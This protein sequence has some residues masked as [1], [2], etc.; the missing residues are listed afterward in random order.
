MKWYL[1]DWGGL[2]VWLFHRINDIHSD[3]LD[4]AMLAV[5]AAAS[6]KLFLLYLILLCLVAIGVIAKTAKE[7]TYVKS[8]WISTIAVFCI[9]YFLDSAFVGI[10]K[11]LMDFPRPPLALSIETVHIIGQAEYHHSL[12]SG[13]SSFAMLMVATIWPLLLAPWQKYIAISFVILVGFSRINLG[14]H[15]P[16]DVMA[17]WVSSLLIVL[18]VRLSVHKIFA[19]ITP[20]GI[21]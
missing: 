12:P 17:G 14:A 15:F 6:Y 21:E 2:N 19:A 11:P 8:L 5:T 3:I 10:L 7:K 20:K 9:A 18:F 4:K 13:H 1:Y 16:A